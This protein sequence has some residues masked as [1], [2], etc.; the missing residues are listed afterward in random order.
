[1]LTF[2]AVTREVCTA[3]REVTATPLQALVL[4]N[5]PQFLEAARVLA[6]QLLRT[7][8]DDV[9]ARA[10]LACRKLLGR[11]PDTDEVT[12]LS[13]S[14][15]E[16]KALFNQDEPA[17]RKLLATGEAKADDSLPVADLAATSLMVNAIMNMDE[18]IV[19][20]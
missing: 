13:R 19:E 18:F 6:G 20:R 3:K 12:I 17:A 10:R 2:D 14:F 8:P 15:A 4:L 16:Q 1:M 9:A 5:D 7:Y 11:L